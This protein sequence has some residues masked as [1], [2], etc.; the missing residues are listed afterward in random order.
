M[1]AK[2]LWALMASMLASNLSM[3]KVKEKEEHLDPVYFLA[4]DGNVAAALEKLKSIDPK[5]LT[6]TEKQTRKKYFE[7]FGSKAHP[8][9]PIGKTLVEE[10]IGIYR[11]YWDQVLL[12]KLKQDQ[13][14]QYLFKKLGPIVKRLGG[15]SGEFSENEYDRVAEFLTMKLKETGYYAKI[16]V[17]NPHLN[18]MAWRQQTTKPFEVDLGNG[19]IQ[20]VDVVLMDDFVS[21]GW[22]AY[23]TFDKMHV[24]GWVGDEALYCVASSYDLDGE[25]FKVSFLAHEARHFADKKKYSN[26]TSTDLEY[27]AKLTELILAKKS[28]ED[29]FRK[30]ILEQREN[31]NNPHSYASFL[32]VK[33][34]SNKLAKGVNLQSFRSLDKT[35]VQEISKAL[36]KENDYEQNHM[37]ASAK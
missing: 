26:L 30:F 14:Y 1:K 9:H 27:R 7:R 16:G 6:P 10:L 24:G 19:E 21:L 11:N 12:Q 36:L 32:L 33:G 34:I 20:K 28:F 5:L 37:R 29:V 23:A 18:F 13:G 4:L 2:I 8:I 25:D 3:A 17:V 35:K 31:P 15:N 22:A